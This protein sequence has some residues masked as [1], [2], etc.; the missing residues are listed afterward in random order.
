M[1]VSGALPWEIPT[2]PMI[3]PLGGLLTMLEGKEGLRAAPLFIPPHHPL[4]HPPTVPRTAACVVLPQQ[5]PAGRPAT[6][7]SPRH[8]HALASAQGLGLVGVGGAAATP[9]TKSSSSSAPPSPLKFGVERL[10]A[11]EPRK[12][13]SPVPAMP[14]PAMFTS[15]LATSSGTCPVLP[16]SSG[17]GSSTTCPVITTVT[18]STHSSVP[19]PGGPTMTCPVIPSCGC[20]SKCP[21]ECGYYYS[22]LYTAHHPAHLLPYASLYGSSMGAA[23]AHRHEVMGVTSGSHGR[24]KRT[25]TRAVFSN[26]QRKGLEKRFQLQKYITKPDR[27]Q[28][29]ATLGLTDAQ[30]KVWFQNRRMKWRH[31]EIKK[32]EQQQQQ[33]KQQMPGEQHHQEQQHPEQQ[34]QQQGTAAEGVAAVSGEEVGADLEGKDGVDIGAHLRPFDEDDDYD[35]DDDVDEDEIEEEEDDDDDEGELIDPVDGPLLP[36]SAPSECLRQMTHFEDKYE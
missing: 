13:I 16:L 24:R 33:Q 8:H 5:A 10:L 34:Q 28:L 9:Y 21:G 15:P 1:F 30:V 26:L 4:P 29:A 32:R 31:A 3:P 2:P 25:W 7:V 6:P 22:P 36:P 12:E 27:R 20:D 11:S 35:H 18:T 23:T 17:L 19:C 14:S